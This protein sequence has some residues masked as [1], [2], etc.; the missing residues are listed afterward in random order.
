[1]TCN[2]NN[3][4]RCNESTENMR[5][6]NENIEINGLHHDHGGWMPKMM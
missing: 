3:L 2:V 4:W 1:M 6:G 5:G